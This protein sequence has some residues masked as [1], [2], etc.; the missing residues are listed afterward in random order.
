MTQTKI[1]VTAIVLTY[2]E[3]INMA[4]CLSAMDEIDDIIIVDSGSEDETITEAKRIRP[5]VRIFSHPFK[6]FGDQRNWALDNCESPHSWIIFI[7]AD[8][9]CT[10]DFIGELRH[11]I[12][13][14]GDA[15]GAFV[16][17]KNYFLGRWLKHSTMYPSYQL[18]VLKRGHV[19]FRKEGHGQREMTE[20]RC[21]YFRSSWLHN[22][23]SK[24]VRQWIDRHNQYSS[25]EAELIMLLRA[26]RLDWSAIFSFD[27]IIRRR[28]LKRIAAHA[29]FRPF[30][31]FFY[32]YVL[33]GGFIDGRAGLHYCALNFAHDV[34]I[35]I[36]LAESHLSSAPK[37]RTGSAPYAS[38][39]A[40][41]RHNKTSRP[42]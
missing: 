31:R 33:R 26:E 22:A 32:T 39:S 6:D 9:Y 41:K 4:P 14:P 8:E 21:I 24:G 30:L 37:I 42:H 15:V 13:A 38:A 25:E 34:H 3:A 36:K 23:F 5:D 17:G 12:A 29:P 7:D 27:P 2:N 10:E 40:P 11:F 1:P 16:A 28:A 35:M 18:R 19:R 20:G